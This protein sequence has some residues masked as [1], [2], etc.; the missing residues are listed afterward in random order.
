[1]QANEVI[2]YIT[3]TGELLT[4]K[5]LIFD[6]QSMQSRIIKIGKLS[7]VPVRGLATTVN[8]PIISVDELKAGLNNNTLE[9]VDVRTEQEHDAFDIGGTHIP[10]DEVEGYLAYF[11]G[12][13]PQV[14]YCSSGNRSDEAVKLILKRIPNANVF[15]LAGGLKAYIG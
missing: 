9:L 13:K 11:T 12:N 10:L 5:V 7:K 2:K 8:I 14:L 1:M 6:A 4:G 3:Q 15:S